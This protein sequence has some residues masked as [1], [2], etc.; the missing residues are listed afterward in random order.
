M[1]AKHEESRDSN[2]DC[3]SCASTAIIFGTIVLKS[4][5]NTNS[6]LENHKLGFPGVTDT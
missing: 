4:K 1:V 2:H 3:I 6:T 5:L